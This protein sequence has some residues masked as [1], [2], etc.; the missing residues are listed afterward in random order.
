MCWWCEDLALIARG[1]DELCDV[2]AGLEAGE[3]HT[4]CVVAAAA[5]ADV[6]DME[7]ED[8]GSAAE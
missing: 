4:D 2:E 6:V 7:G 3:D 5:A 1:S 8:F